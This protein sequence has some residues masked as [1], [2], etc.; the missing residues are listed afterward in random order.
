MHLTVYQID[1]FADRPFEGNPA[2]VVPLSRWLPNALMQSIAMELNLPETAF[3]VH[4]GNLFEIRW[5]T[6]EYEIDLCGHATLAAAFVIFSELEPALK[7]LEFSSQSGQLLVSR[8]GETLCLDF[9]SLPAKSM[10]IPEGLSKALGAKLLETGRSR[11]I[12]CVLESESAVRNLKPDIKLL[13]KYETHGFIVTA[14]GDRV[15]C[16]SRCFFPRESV[17]EDHVT[18][19][20]HC[21]V[22]PYWAKKLRKSKIHAKQLSPRGGEMICELK[23]DRVFISGRA[24]KVMEGRFLLKG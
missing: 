5:F 19:S 20:S 18:G 2:A 3:F 10:P 22:I 1:A 17:V 24:V 9:P 7:S 23:N 8:D 13:A 21:T 16:V 11:E 4:S 14:K 12:L 15:D 6:P